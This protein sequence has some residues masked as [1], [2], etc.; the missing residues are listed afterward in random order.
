M[1]F[2][3]IT[4]SQAICLPTEKI[5]YVNLDTY[6]INQYFPQNWKSYI[7]IEIFIMNTNCYIQ[8]TCTTS[9]AAEI[10]EDAKSETRMR[11][12]RTP[13]ISHVE[14]ILQEIVI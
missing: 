12:K 5:R 6:I 3:I 8:I 11:E 4:M 13:N 1:T 2:F 7:R 9:E 10:K 14:C